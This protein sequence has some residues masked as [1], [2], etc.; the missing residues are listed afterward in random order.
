MIFFCMVI[1][2]SFNHRCW[3]TPSINQSPI[4][5]ITFSL[6]LIFLV[7]NQFAIVLSSFLRADVNYAVADRATT[8]QLLT[9]SSLVLFIE[10]LNKQLW[11]PF[12]LRKRKIIPPRYSEYFV[13]V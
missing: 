11:H 13:C 2:V 8:Y 12:W 5:L 10:P 4:M 7:M 9:G 6:L 1:I 3:F